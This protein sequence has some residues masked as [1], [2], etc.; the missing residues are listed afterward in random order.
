M[1]ACGVGRRNSDRS[2][3][4][5]NHLAIDQTRPIAKRNDLPDVEKRSTEETTLYFSQQCFLNLLCVAFHCCIQQENH[6]E[7]TATRSLD[8][9]EFMGHLCPVHI[10]RTGS[11]TVRGRTEYVSHLT[12]CI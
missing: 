1:F 6:S 4:N 3:S 12:D 9:D 7:V 5:V 2:N 11:R 10:K 8:C